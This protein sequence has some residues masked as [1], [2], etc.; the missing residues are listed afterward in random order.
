L[1]RIRALKIGFFKNERLA[2]L[3]PWHR[4]LFEG[5]W[6]LADREGRLE[7]RPRRI[8]AEIFP[9]DDGID[10]S[11]MLQDLTRGSDPQIQRYIVN[12][13]G[14]IWICKFLDHQRPHYSEPASTYPEPPQWVTYPAE[15]SAATPEEVVSA[16]SLMGNGEW[17]MGN[18]NTADPSAELLPVAYVPEDLAGLWNAIDPPLPQCREL[19]VDR[20]KKARK[21]LKER[22][23]DQWREVVARIGASD[24]CRGL[25]PSRNG[26]K[27]WIATF[28]WLLKPETAVRV[29]EGKYD[30]RIGVSSGRGNAA[31]VAFDQAGDAR[32]A[33]YEQRT[34]RHTAEEGSI[35]VV[36]DRA[37]GDGGQRDRRRLSDGRL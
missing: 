15:Y 3:S 16:T 22:P 12:G 8:K 13:F 33:L 26:D 14:Y 6:L 34:E 2:E 30:N 35:N 7:D 1:A 28:D 32:E 21:R 23:F 18:G 4:L 25:V 31:A 37:P 11:S 20:K 29:L 10:V 9:Y 36:G 27:P 5:L 17:V 19:T 24:F